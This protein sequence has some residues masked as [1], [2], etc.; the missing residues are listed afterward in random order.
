MQSENKVIVGMRLLLKRSIL[1][2][3]LERGLKMTGM[4]SV[5]TW[6][7]LLIPTSKGLLRLE[8][9]KKGARVK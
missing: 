3:L 5:A 4:L 6:N 7:S 9:R 2:S 8:R 1:F